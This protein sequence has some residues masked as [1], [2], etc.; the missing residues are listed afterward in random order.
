MRPD[1]VESLRAIQGA[2]NEVLLPELQTPFAQEAAQAVAMLAESLAAE[3]DTEVEDLLADNSTIRQILVTARDELAA[4]NGN[5][6]A[7]EA[8]KVIEAALE[9]EADGRLTVSALNTENGT[10]RLALAT[11][12]E[13]L[14]DMH[15]ENGYERLASSRAAA[16]NHLRQVA[17]RGWSFFDVSGFRERI[18][19]ARAEL[20]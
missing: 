18:V 16:Y 3:W 20:Q 11:L 12:L 13:L 6:I 17:V 5:D 8:V 10:L 14:E 9:S 2:V 19:Q 7:A 15:G 1:A 4:L